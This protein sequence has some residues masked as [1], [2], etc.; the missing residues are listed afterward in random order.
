MLQIPNLFV[1][2]GG[3]FAKNLKV[4]ANCRNLQYGSSTFEHLFVN[5]KHSPLALDRYETAGHFDKFSQALLTP[6]MSTKDLYAR[7]KLGKCTAKRCKENE[8][9]G[10]CF[11]SA[12]PRGNLVVWV[13][14]MQ[15][16]KKTIPG[17]RFSPKKVGIAI[18]IRELLYP[19][20]I[21][22]SSC[23]FFWVGHENGL[24]SW[25]WGLAS[26]MLD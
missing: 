25:V 18:F 23:F 9:E 15:I 16:P 6:Q 13:T 24:W 11:E 17:S 19:K 14:W 22:L 8:K 10:W 3:P 20:M 4:K 26:R 1:S 7:R 21:C 12:D 2:A 5:W